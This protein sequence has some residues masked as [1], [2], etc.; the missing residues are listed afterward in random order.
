MPESDAQRP[1]PMTAS[2]TST[3]QWQSF[4]VRMRHR[5]AE[6]CLLRA[7]QAFLAGSLD[8]ARAATDEAREL[9]A[10]FPGIAEMDRRLNAAARPPDPVIR[11]PAVAVTLP[12][13]PVELTL[14]PP[15][16]DATPAPSPA[17]RPVRPG[18]RPRDVA[19]KP[20]AAPG[21]LRARARAEEVTS[22]LRA[23]DVRFADVPAPSPALPTGPD[24]QLSG[25]DVQLSRET[26]A[27]NRRRPFYYSALALA[28]ASVVVL[29]AGLFGWRATLPADEP[30]PVYTAL[31]GD[32][33]LPP[34]IDRDAEPDTTSEPDTAVGSGPGDLET[35]SAPIAA[36]PAAVPTSGRPAA[37]L[38]GPGSTAARREFEPP[39]PPAARPAAEPPPVTA[40]TARAT[41]TAPAASPRDPATAAASGRVGSPVPAP[42]SGEPTVSAARDAAL[43]VSSARNDAPSGVAAREDPPQAPQRAPIASLNPADA[44][45]LSATALPAPSPAAPLSDTAASSRSRP[46]EAAPRVIDPQ[47]AV[48]ATL[49]RYEAAYSG[50]DVSAARAVWPS[51]DQR[52]LARAFDGLASQRVALE[53]CDVLV[54]GATARATCS[55]RAE[56]TPKVGGGQHR[57][58]RRW[59]FEL[60]NAGGTWQI[61]RAEAK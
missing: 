49:G 33:T 17:P 1:V 30:A 36:E 43:P 46:T 45:P 32:V 44:A 53:N 10:G 21:W 29:T 50:L 38:P 19:P 12:V 48:R 6:R 9:D 24:V 13:P 23:K 47:A 61:V 14:N 11:T 3:P 15:T 31:R 16:A 57:Q 51:V 2:H 39:A 26:P 41:V 52:A 60:A 59:A 34:V 54:N 4:E 8:E 42:G 5:R 58:N 22:R 20:S 18:A 40:P 55:G 56:W 25:P 35:A 37:I 28:C 27:G 7:D